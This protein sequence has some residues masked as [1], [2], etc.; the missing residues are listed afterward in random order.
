MHLPR[1]LDRQGPQAR[2]AGV[3]IGEPRGALLTA[4]EM[5]AIETGAIERGAATGL[6]LMDRAGHGVVE[7][8]LAWRPELSGGRRRA[9]VL[10]GPGN[11]GGDGFV[12]ARLLRERAW[13]VEVWLYGRD[14]AALDRLPPD[15]GVNA[16]RWAAM[17]E[18]R[19]WDDAAI[20]D[21]I[22]SHEHDIVVD[23]LFGTGLTR[24]TSEDTARTRR[25]VTSAAFADAVP[26]LVAVD[27]PS[28]ICSDSGANL[29]GAFPVNLTVSFHRAKRGHVLS[30]ARP[31]DGGA[32]FCA[33][34][35]VADIG[36]G[37]AEPSDPQCRLVGPPA[38]ARIAKRA[39]HKYAYG[40]ALV[41]AGGVARGGAARLAARGAL[42]VGAGLVT[43]GCPPAA[44]IENAAR[45]DAIMLR[46]VADAQALSALLTDARLNALCLGPGLGTGERTR[47]L[48]AAATAAE[49][50]TVLDADALT[51]FAGDPA[52]LFAHLHE[53]CVLTPHDGEFARIFPDLAAPL[54]EAAT[55][56]PAP[57]R[58]DAVQAAAARAG[59]T[60]LLKGPDT[61]IARP[62]GAAR[63]HAATGARAVPWLAT[64]GAGDVL[65]GL[66]AGLMARGAAPL[67]AAG[68]AVWL[69][70]E[71]ARRVGPGLIAEDLPE[72]LPRVLRDLGA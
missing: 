38:P 32:R 13:G 3:T 17:G 71:A 18:I 40:H 33:E 70:A 24:G 22:D 46:R 12:V 67:E 16:R 4:A 21:R 30:D 53:G 15:A 37:H 1:R 66:I 72:A 58:V 55:T 27:L 54:A 20:A 49:R 28:G 25:S 39:G 63:V 26:R 7:A 69:H 59:C 35:V 47:A 60:V 19:P 11:N 51:A 23:A 34:V 42:R 45:L 44:L 65:S 43:V 41:L 68:D 14:P 56:G 9:L 8:I 50:A 2:N 5:R 36:L 6:E 10:C 64:A 57:S 61:V 29:G 48:V 31:L 52:A 62:D